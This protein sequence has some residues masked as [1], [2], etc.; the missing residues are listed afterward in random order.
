MT[1]TKVEQ[2]VEVTTNGPY[3][4]TG[5]IPLYRVRKVPLEGARGSFKDWDL[6]EKI[7]TEDEYWLCRCGHS[8][9]KPFCTGMHEKI[10]FDGTET[11]PTDTYKERSEALGGTKLAVRDDRGICAHAAFCSNELTNIWKAAKISDDDDELRETVRT[12]AGN[13]P[14]GA[15]TVEVD[16]QSRRERHGAADLDPRGRVDPAARWHQDH[17]RRRAADRD[18]SAD[19][20]VPVRAVEHQAAVRRVARESRL[21]R[22]MTLYALVHGAWHGA[23]CF[24]KLIPELEQRGHR[25]I[26]VDL[27]CETKGV[28]SYIAPVVEAIEAARGGDEVVVLGHSMAG[29]TIPHVA[30]RTPVKH[31]IYLCALLQKPGGTPSET[32][33]QEPDIVQLGFFGGT[34]AN[35]DGTFTW[36]PEEAP[37]WFFHDCTDEDAAWATSKLRPQ[38]LN[39]DD[40]DPIDLTAFPSS[41]IVCAEDR[42]VRPEWSRKRAPDWLGVE[43]VELPGSHSPFLS[44]P[45]ELA[46]LIVSIA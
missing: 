37:K 30:A 13:C 6:Y 35:D 19:G 12:M 29:F 4:V 28:A 26:A 5:G 45:A 27:P 10:G 23:W 34:V 31:L 38:S 39:P 36:R 18:A 1:E 3:H 32:F 33:A 9:N 46:D 24:D 22:R 20:A 2:A 25:A 40:P 8:T 15:L 44:R 21:Q 7:E 17:A 43:P 42:A 11:A 14:S 41:Y 16:G